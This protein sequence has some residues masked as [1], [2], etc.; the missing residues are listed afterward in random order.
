M[1]VPLVFFNSFQSQEL[2]TVDNIGIVSDEFKK[3]HE[4]YGQV[5]NI[6]SKCLMC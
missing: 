4:D 2:Q 5:N 6:S 1:T 3:M